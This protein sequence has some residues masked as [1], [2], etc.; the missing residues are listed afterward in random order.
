[1]PLGAALRPCHILAGET[2]HL[3]GAQPVRSCEGRKGRL[4]LVPTR[5]G[6]LFHLL[7]LTAFPLRFN[8]TAHYRLHELTFNLQPFPLQGQGCLRRALLSVSS[9]MAGGCSPSLPSLLLILPCSHTRRRVADQVSAMAWSNLS[10]PVRSLASLPS[11]S[12]GAARFGA[13]V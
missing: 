13:H 3:I 6:S 7:L 4:E 9:P 1:M 10:W 8:T 2:R 12:R 11:L 5:V